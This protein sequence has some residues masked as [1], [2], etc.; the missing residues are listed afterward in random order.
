MDQEQ[1]GITPS[2]QKELRRVFDHLSNFSKKRKL[3][4]RLN[5]LVDRRQ[6][7][8][9]AKKSSFEIQVQDKDGGLMSEAQ[10]D[11]ETEK[12]TVQIE[13][14]QKQIGE[15]DTYVLCACLLIVFFFCCCLSLL[16]RMVFFGRSLSCITHTHT[17]THTP[18]TLFPLLCLQ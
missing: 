4:V 3:Y 1:K 2:E 9:Q 15:F 6:K 7:L 16:H 13:L 17:H 10:I 12:L 14:L 18:L 11:E 5:P 8:V